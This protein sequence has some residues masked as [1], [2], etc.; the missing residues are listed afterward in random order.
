MAS[1]SAHDVELAS[2]SVAQPRPVVFRP[3]IG[4][5]E[6]A[7]TEVL[8]ETDKWACTYVLHDMLCLR[9]LQCD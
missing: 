9:T 4:Y 3:V 2:L 6:K 8:S 7:A 5:T 1:Y